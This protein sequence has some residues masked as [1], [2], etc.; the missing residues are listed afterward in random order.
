[1]SPAKPIAGHF[2]GRAIEK[3]MAPLLAALGK[4]LK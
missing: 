4:T 2:L 3:K 1:M